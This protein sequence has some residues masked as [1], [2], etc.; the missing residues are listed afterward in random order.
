MS[1]RTVSRRSE[2]PDLVQIVVINTVNDV[3][4]F[5]VAQNVENIGEGDD[6]TNCQQEMGVENPAWFTDQTDFTIYFNN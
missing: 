3:G 1:Q 5:G 6:C 4:R 2:R